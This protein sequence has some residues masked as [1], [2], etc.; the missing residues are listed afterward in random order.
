MEG[1]PASIK[2]WVLLSCVPHL[3]LDGA[4]LAAWA[5]GATRIVV[6][7][8]R[9]RPDTADAVMRAAAQRVGTASAPV[10]V[11]VAR[12]P[13]GYVAGEESALLSWLH[14]DP[15]TP[16]WRPD[17]S[18]PLE[19]PRGAALVHNVE[20]LAHMAL[21]ARYG[22]ASFRGAGTAD[23]AGTTLVTVSG[24][25]EH[26]G[27]YEV[28]MGTTLGAIVRQARPTHEV[29]AVLTGGF[30]GSWVPAAALGTRYAPRD[31]AAVG[32]VVGP[33]VLVVLTRLSCGIAETR[34][35]ARYM[36]G[37]SVGQCGPCV[38][39][40]PSVAD[41]LERLESG[42]AD[43]HAIGRIE[44]R[45]ASVDGRGACRHPDGV[46]RMVRSAL[47][48]FA[49]DAAAHAGGRPCAFRDEPSVLP[50]SVSPTAGSIKAGIR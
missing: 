23:A 26:P 33:G 22:P 13:G 34:R 31:L 49:A 29:A 35:V 17:K 32:G 21:I 7:V 18:H 27:V 42:Y 44:A 41:D 39:G 28:A 16:S 8:S 40:L 46:A 30:G 2:D 50:P 5:L 3:V 11:E 47:S 37:E 19:L 36:A 20:T 38:F 43:P 14:G 1:E 12:P 10:P 4:E 24:G 45:V 9:D 25:V 6:C 48:V 15:G